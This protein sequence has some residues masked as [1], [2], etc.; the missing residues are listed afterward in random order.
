MCADLSFLKDDSTLAHVDRMIEKAGASK[1]PRRYLGASDLGD[2]CSRRLWIKLHTDYR[3]SFEGRLYRLFETGHIIERRVIRDL[4]RAGLKVT[5]RQLKFKDFKNKFRGH[6]DGIVEGLRE[7]PKP[8]ILEIKSVNDK[9]YQDFLKNGMTSNEKYA[10]QIQI[11]MG[12]FGLDRG[13][14]VLENKNTSARYY[15]RVKFDRELFERLKAK[16]LAIIEAKTP[17]APINESPMWWQCRIC[18]LNTEEHCRK[19]YGG[20]PF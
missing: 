7:S 13:Y 4:K 6:C 15:E 18:P 11:Y 14:F 10:A 12:Y 3:P 17:P 16:A 5:G 19:D 9:G 1:R 20:S 2:E 8:H